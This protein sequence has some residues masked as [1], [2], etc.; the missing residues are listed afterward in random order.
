MLS[1]KQVVEK[2]SP[3]TPFGTWEENRAGWA[4]FYVLYSIEKEKY[5]PL[6]RITPEME[7]IWDKCRLTGAVMRLKDVW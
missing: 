1:D 3:L 4:E 7:D 5:W 6:V 2:F